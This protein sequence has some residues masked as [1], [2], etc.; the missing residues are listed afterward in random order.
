MT[1]NRPFRSQLAVVAVGALGTCALTLAFA[2]PAASDGRPP[3]VTPLWQPTT[4]PADDD[5]TVA[6]DVPDV[7]ITKPA[8]LTPEQ[9]SRI[10]YLEIRAMRTDD[11]EP[12]RVTVKIS[13]DVIE[14]FLLSMEGHEDF[15]GAKPKREFNKMTPPQK[16]HAIAHYKGASFAD[17]VLIESDPEVFVEFKKQ[18]LP[19]VLRTCATS[20]C[21]TTTN[22]DA[23]GFA[24]INDPKRTEQS[25]YANFIILND[26][27]VNKRKMIDRSQPENSLLLTYM[28]PRSEVRVEL[29]HPGDIEYQLA[30]PSRKHRRH[31]LLLRWIESLKHP[32]EDYGVHLLPRDE[33]LAEEP[34][35]LDAEPTTQPADATDREP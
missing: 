1:R 26:I 20:G 14:E 35:D 11:V 28:L 2:L 13:K 7:D 17:K 22:R 12:D 10:R 19:L 3:E 27:E 15:R 24:L 23:E 25:V 34:I 32:T 5:D 33:N 16:L 30:L 18:V 9:I 21:H 31:D 8:T 6:A 4:Q 29:R